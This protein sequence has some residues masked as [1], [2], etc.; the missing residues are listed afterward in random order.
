MVGA[1]Y[2]RHDR[3]RGRTTAQ[4]YKAMNLAGVVGMD[5][6][7][8]N[9]VVGAAIWVESGFANRGTESFELSARSVDVKADAALKWQVEGREY[10]QAVRVA[11]KKSRFQRVSVVAVGIVVFRHQP[12][13]ARTFWARVAA[14]DGL[15]R[16]DP[17]KALL[18]HLDSPMRRGS[19]IADARK[20]AACWNAAF[21][22]R[23]L[24]KVYEIGADKRGLTILGT[25]FRAE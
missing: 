20:V 24:S 23:E 15:R 10:W 13:I 25:P 5:G 17:E 16:N 4:Q 1:L 7:T 2:A 22:G 8:L 19:N 12:E 6:K 3:H 18:R 9:A 11:A 14:D 21:E